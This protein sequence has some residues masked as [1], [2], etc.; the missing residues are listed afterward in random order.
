MKIKHLTPIILALSALVSCNTDKGNKDGN[1]TSIS[2]KESSV[3]TSVDT[4]FSP[5]KLNLVI[6]PETAPDK[7]VT[8]SVDKPEVLTYRSSQGDFFANSVGEA[9]VTATANDGGKTAS[10]K[11]KVVEMPTVTPII[12]TTDVSAPGAS[13]GKISI[14]F[15]ILNESGIEPDWMEIEFHGESKPEK[16]TD[17]SKGYIMFTRENL[18]AYTYKISYSLYMK[19]E[20]MG[21]VHDTFYLTVN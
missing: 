2:F 16:Q 12:E 15:S 18:P 21:C 8:W 3:T 11:V 1:I 19:S 10:L 7:S 20:M 17:F 5:E 14:K 4:R 6:L 9:T 13:D